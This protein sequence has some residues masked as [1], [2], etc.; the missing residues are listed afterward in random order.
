MSPRSKPTGEVWC[1]MPTGD[2][3]LDEFESIFRSAVKDVFRFEPPQLSSG[4][5]VTDL[6]RAESAA[7]E[8]KVRSLLATIDSAEQMQWVDLAGEDWA[9]PR[10]GDP[11]DNLLAQIRSREPDLIVTYRHLLDTNKNS[12]YTLG[13][14]VDT[15]TQAI[16]TPVLLLPPPIDGVFSFDGGTQRVMVVTDHLTGNDQL[17]NYGVEFT[18]QEG[19]LYLAHVEDHATMERFLDTIDKLRRVDSNL[20]REQIPEKL[21]SMPADYIESIVEVLR[22]REIRETLVPVVRM[23]HGLTD[24]ERLMTEH[25]IDLL[26]LSGK[27]ESQLAMHGMAH[28]I[29]VELRHKPLLLL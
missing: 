28:A 8:V 26:I 23:G 11:I 18:S 14:V 16:P 22:A 15:L 20:A 6:P 25:E 7:L 27:D 19:T 17:V 21:L 29:A 2:R 1:R 13:S 10:P 9:A 4:L 12:P 5:L 3:K 24:Y